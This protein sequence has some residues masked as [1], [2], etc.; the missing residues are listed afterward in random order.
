[1]QVTHFELVMMIGVVLLEHRSFA[2]N[3]VYSDFNST[4]GLVLQQ[5]TSSV[6]GKLRLSPAIA[7][8]G[9]GGAWLEAKQFIKDGFDTT[10]Q[11]Q[12][13]EKH[14]SGADGLAFVI[15]NG[16]MPRLGQSGQNLGYGGITNQFVIHFDNYHWADHPTAG[17]Y[18]EIAVLAASSPDQPVYNVAENILAS[19]T[20]QITF[21]DGAM[22]A[23]RILYVPGNLQVFL[24]DLKNPVMTVY[25]NLNKVMDLDDGRAWVGFTAASGADWQN[26]DLVSWTFRDAAATTPVNGHIV[27]PM[28]NSNPLAPSLAPAYFGSGGQPVLARPLSIDPLFGY[29]LPHEV[30]LTHRIEASTNLL[31]WTPLKNAAYYFLDGESTNYP[32]RFYRFQKVN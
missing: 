18:D 1:M 31:E 8:L 7:G 14:S 12:I 6:D 5:H 25:V 4:A 20:R 27:S 24:D 15:Q 11:I 28:A 17:R 19:V 32:T 23:V 21:S 16:T 26:H 29:P 13:T 9:W 30:G 2:R 3:I 22:H 10:F